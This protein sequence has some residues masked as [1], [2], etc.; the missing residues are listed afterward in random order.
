YPYLNLTFIPFT[1]LQNSSIH[2][3]V[4][5]LLFPKSSNSPASVIL[6]LSKLHDMTVKCGE[7]A[8]FI[9]AVQE[10]TLKVTWKHESQTINETEKVKMSQNGNVMLL[11]I[12]NVQLMEQG[13][14]SCTVKNNHGEKTTAAVLT[15]EGKP[16]RFLRALSNLDVPIQSDAEFKCAVIGNPQPAVKWLKETYKF[17]YDASEYSCIIP[18]VKAENE[19]EYICL[20]SNRH[21]ETTCSSYLTVEQQVGQSALFTCETEPAPNVR[22]QWFKSGREIYE[23]DKYAVKTLNFLSTLEIIRPQVVD[24]GEYTC[25]ASNSF[26][27]VSSTATL[28]VTGKHLS[29]V[30]VTYQ[31][32]MHITLACAASY[33]RECTNGTFIK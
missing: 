28:N 32:I 10:L 6:T 31:Y 14:Y 9:C 4:V 3:P 18:N 5:F 15:V 11:T 26:G 30:Q 2:L 27:S 8:Q 21:G 12:Q 23:S 13:T 1:C 16:P 17:V 24:F 20:A 19:G 25:K 29:F 22:F 7:I 33:I